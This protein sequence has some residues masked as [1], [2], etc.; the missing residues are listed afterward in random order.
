M[1]TAAHDSLGPTQHS[2]RWSFPEVQS[3]TGSNIRYCWV[4]HPGKDEDID[5]TNSSLGKFKVSVCVRAE[6]GHAA[7]EA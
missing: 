5:V 1:G 4:S 6:Q 2:F 3:S 7:R